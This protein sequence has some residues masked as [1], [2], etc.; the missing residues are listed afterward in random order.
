MR[1]RQAAFRL[2]VL[3]AAFAAVVGL[4]L[5]S[6]LAIRIARA[7]EPIADAPRDAAVAADAAR[8]VVPAGDGAL[9][10]SWNPGPGD[11][12]DV[13]L[14]TIEP[15]AVYWE[16][17][18]HNAIVIR[19]RATGRSTLYNFGIFDFSQANFL[20]NFARGLMTYLGVAEDYDGALDGYVRQGRAITTQVLNLAPAQRAALQAYLDTAVAPENAAYR[21]DYYANNCSTR[22]RDA[23]DHALAG[24]LRRNLGGRSRG[25]TWRMQTRALTAPEPWLYAVTDLGLSSYVDRP[26]SYWEESFVPMTLAA[27]VDD[28]QVTDDAGNAVPLVATKR[29][30]VARGAIDAPPPAVSN[31]VAW[32]LMLAIG[33]GAGL[34]LV[35]AARARAPAARLLVGASYAAWACT[36]AVAGLVLLALWTLTDHAS[37]YAN[38]N[39]F[40]LD[41]LALL[42]LPAALALVR[43]RPV[44]RGAARVATWV[45]AI[46]VAGVAVKIF[47]PF[48]QDNFAWLA[49]LV[50]IHVAYAVILARR[51]AG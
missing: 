13:A 23:L 48:R 20:V 50:P 28:V 32:W 10:A 29:R 7:G 41:P 51:T 25:V 11:A 40:V 37:A 38:E 12:L 27:L 9:R 46:A 35:A 33:V 21:Y 45:A 19:D 30:E 24:A 16:R 39:L 43:G 15:G 49:L 2:R 47:P 42:A 14:V 22:V 34:A 3:L 5:A 4:S 44:G 31:G 36:T 26:V 1:R 17:F 6:L 8:A 18:G